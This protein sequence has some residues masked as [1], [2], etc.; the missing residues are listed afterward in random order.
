MALAVL[1]L[2]S[3]SKVAPDN[4]VE[5]RF[6][7]S[8]QPE[9]VTRAGGEAEQLVA[10][11]AVLQLWQ[12]DALAENIEQ[13]I[14]PG[15][16]QIDFNG[17]KLVKGFDYDVYIWVGNNGYYDTSDL[18]N[19]SLASGKEYDGKTPQFDAFFA[20]TTVNGSQGDGIHNVTLKRPFAKVSFSAPASQETTI[21]FSA[22]TTLN[23]KTGKVSGSRHFQYTV[24][25]MESSVKAF[26]YLFAD[27]EVT[28][29]EYSFKFEDGEIKSVTVPITRNT[30]TNII[31]NN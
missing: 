15:T 14:S 8:I 20:Y 18:R 23:L 12:G 5:M 6:C 28:R 4:E 24:D 29:M 10:N 26:D 3:C 16:A 17:I 7:A 1:A 11:R 25:P 21:A 2:V 22:A 19:V 30:K 9:L 27:E 31:V 13:T